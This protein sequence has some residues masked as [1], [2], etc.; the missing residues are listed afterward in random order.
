[1]DGTFGGFMIRIQIDMWPHGDE[2]RKYNLGEIRIAN[3]G[4]TETQGAYIF[5]LTKRDGGKW[6]SGIL[7]GEFPRKRLGVYDLLFRVLR[8]VVGGRN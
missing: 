1:M 2:K 7:E 6:K 4:G 5:S 3:V 8:Q